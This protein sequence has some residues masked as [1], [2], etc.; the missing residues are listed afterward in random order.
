MND[1]AFTRF[2]AG[3]QRRINTD[4]GSVFFQTLEHMPNTS[5]S[6]PS[7]SLQCV[8]CNDTHWIVALKTNIVRLTL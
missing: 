8:V 1:S 7:F 4:F 6:E 3:E 5:D 2:G